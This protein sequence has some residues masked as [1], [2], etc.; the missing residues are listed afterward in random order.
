MK[1]RILIAVVAIWLLVGVLWGAQTS[2]G[3]SVMGGEAV[4]LGAAIKSAL[5]QIL[6]WIPVT[7]AAIALAVRFPFS[8]ERWARYAVIHLVA[9]AVLGH[10]D[11]LGQV[12]RGLL[13]ALA[14][15]S[16][17]WG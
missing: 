14:G 12:D 15:G 9:A 16:P 4:G 7:L 10:L 2:L 11:H 13:L 3:S 6:P 17:C 1:L 8:R 5:Q